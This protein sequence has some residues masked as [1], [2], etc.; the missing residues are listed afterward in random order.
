MTDKNWRTG[1]FYC[2]VFCSLSFGKCS[3]R[4][5]IIQDKVE[6]LNLEH[7]GPVKKKAARVMQALVE[8]ERKPQ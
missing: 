2:F 6:A 8:G 3:E 1:H 5:G 7:M 4:K